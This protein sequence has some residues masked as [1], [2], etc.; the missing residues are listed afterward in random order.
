MLLIR[1]LLM[2]LIDRLS[3]G[4]AAVLSFGYTMCK[5]AALAAE[6]LIVPP[7]VTLRTAGAP[8]RSPTETST[9]S[10]DALEIDPTFTNVTPTGWVAASPSPEKD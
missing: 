2:M 4:I 6:A 1:P 8:V 7:F 10:S 3:W 9:I 5:A